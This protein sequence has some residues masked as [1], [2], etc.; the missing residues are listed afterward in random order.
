MFSPVT[1]FKVAFIFWPFGV[2]EQ[3]EEKKKRCILSACI[4]SF[5]ILIFCGISKNFLKNCRYFLSLYVLLVS[6]NYWE[7]LSALYQLN[8][9]LGQALNLSVFSLVLE[10]KCTVCLSGLFHWEQLPDD[11]MD[12]QHK[13]QA[14]GLHETR[15]NELVERSQ[16]RVLTEVDGNCKYAPL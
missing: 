15:N 6:T 7:K 9:P 12:T 8:A 13:T 16:N 10:R 2:V 4:S 3:D 14:C 11:S 1:K 5:W